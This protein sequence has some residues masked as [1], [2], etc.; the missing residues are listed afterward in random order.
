M[1][2]TKLVR[3]LTLFPLAAF[4]AACG[5]DDDSG[6]Q[7]SIDTGKS[8]DQLTS[9]ESAQLCKDLTSWGEKAAKGLEPKFCKLV[10]VFAES[11][12]ECEK[13]VKDCINAPSEPDDGGMCTPPTNCDATVAEVQ[14]CLEDSIKALDGYLDEFP[15]CAELASDSVMEPADPGEPASCKTLEQRCPDYAKLVDDDDLDTDE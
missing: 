2:C 5:G 15:S 4:V 3:A 9:S 6:F 14:K 7:T 11:K 13:S 1:N 8:I 10:G 12:A